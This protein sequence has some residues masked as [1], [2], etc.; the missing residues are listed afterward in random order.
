[1]CTKLVKSWLGKFTDWLAKKQ[2][3]VLDSAP[4][5]IKKGL[6][7]EVEIYRNNHKGEIPTK[8]YLLNK[9]KSTKNFMSGCKNC[10]ITV[11]NL[12]DMIVDVLS[13]Y[14]TPTKIAK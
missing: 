3:A 14:E 1:M 5:I 4:N 8:Y 7:E 12:E 9:C 11:S 6:K 13:K 10:G 2:L